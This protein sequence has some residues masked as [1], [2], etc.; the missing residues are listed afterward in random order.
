MLYQTQLAIAPFAAS[1][2]LT[3]SRGRKLCR[4]AIVSFPGRLGIPYAY[5]PQQATSACRSVLFLDNKQSWPPCL[6]H[7]HTVLTPSSTTA[8]PSLAR[9]RSERGLSHN[10]T[11][12]VPADAL[13]QYPIPFTLVP[14]TAVVSPGRSG[15]SGRGFA[16]GHPLSPLLL[17]VPSQSGNGINPLLPPCSPLLLRGQGAGCRSKSVRY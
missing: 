8:E 15:G 13:G 7:P 16:L 17:I 1:P 5:P 10:W 11:T 12:L 4:P 14:L 3:S 2:S 6:L 9:S